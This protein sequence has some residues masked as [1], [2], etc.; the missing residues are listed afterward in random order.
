MS[1][2]SARFY[3]YVKHFIPFLTDLPDEIIGSVFLLLNLLVFEKF[4]DEDFQARR[5]HIISIVTI[6]Q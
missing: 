5:I 3:V 4:L 6:P 2:I 1:S